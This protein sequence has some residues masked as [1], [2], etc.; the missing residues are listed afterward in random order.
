MR[1]SDDPRIA[2]A[3]VF[4]VIRNTSVPYGISL[5]DAPNL[6]TTRWRVVVDH[7]DRLF[8]VESAISPNVFCVDLAQLDLSEGAPVRW[9]D[10][11][12]D[13]TAVHAGEVSASFV[14]TEPF[15]FEPAM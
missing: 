1:Q 2:A 6:S 7:K 5:D 15:G 11:G 10:L 12:I 4:S 8:Y 3:S 9:L 13:M 14:E